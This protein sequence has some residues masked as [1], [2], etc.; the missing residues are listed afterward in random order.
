MN[1]VN[2]G[3]VE[4]DILKKL[5]KKYSG[6]KREEV[7]E[8]A[9]LGYDTALVDYGD[10][11]LVITTDP[12]TASTEDIGK[13]AINVNLNDI[14]TRGITPIG[15]MITLLLPLN[16]D[17]KELECIA[18]DLHEESLKNNIQIT[19]GHTEFT[20]AV[21]RPVVNVTMYGKLEKKLNNN[22][23]PEQGDAIIVT[24]T[25][26]IEGVGIICNEKKKELSNVIRGEL[27]E[28]GIK[29]INSTSVL[30]EGLLAKDFNFKIMHDITEGGLKG[31]VYEISNALNMGCEIDARKIKFDEITMQVC[32]IYNIDILSLISSGSMLIVM[33]KNHYI[34]YMDKLKEQ[35]IDS[36]KVGELKGEHVNIITLNGKKEII[37][38]T[39]K[40]EL[41]KVI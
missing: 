30:K 9:D 20:D 4:S 22:K 15:A 5:L 10:N 35:G 3:K 1:K 14:A 39:Q 31:A 34:A 16:S 41:Y 36:Y 37:K 27:L 18:K 33:D 7:I 17:E 28:E 38:K 29:K 32:R 11:L 23:K 6:A 12:I 8:G 13:L 2:A 40:D 21:N 24:K 19:G 25:L 26:G